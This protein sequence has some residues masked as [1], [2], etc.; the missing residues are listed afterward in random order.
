[1]TAK[2]TISIELELGWGKH[3]IPSYKCFSKD[4]SE[5]TKYLDKLLQI[6][7]KNEVPITFDIV[8]HLF[9]KDCED[10]EEELYPDNWWKEHDRSTDDLE[11]LFH[12]PDLVQ[13]I[14]DAEVDHEIATHTYSH[15]MMDEVDSETISYELE[16]VRDI[17]KEWNIES[18]ISIVAPRHR[19]INSKILLNNGIKI[20]RE[21]SAKQSEPD[22][23]ISAWLLTRDHPVHDPEIKNDILRTY[24]TSYP[25]LTFSGGVLPKGQV[26]A[27]DHFKYL[28]LKIRQLIHERYLKTGV[29]TAIKRDSYV[30]FWTHLWDMANKQQWDTIESF[31][32][33]LGEKDNHEKVKIHRMKDISKE[34]LD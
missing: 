23:L 7:D 2:V 12:A 16:L 1:M 14:K 6:C 15:I 5:E 22:H 19:D 13:K 31:I 20:V 32:I 21:P 33:W 17:H 10:I 26:P 30:H 25:S 8:G 24:S 18:P 11:R 28:P 34:V 3:D 9:E 4:R 29:K 27:Q